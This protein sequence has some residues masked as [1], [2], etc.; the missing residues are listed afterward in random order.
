MLSTHTIVVGASAAGLACAACLKRAGIDH[1]LLEKQPHVA[2]AWRN[3]Y[4]RLHL[5]THKANSGLPFV[6]FDRSVPKY[7]SR[8][9]VVAYLEA[10][11]RKMGLEPVFNTHVTAIRRENNQWLVQ[12]TG[13]TYQAQQVVIAT[14]STHTPKLAVIPGLDSFPGP[15]LH[16]SQYKNGSS[17]SGQ[18]V[19]VVGFGNSGGEQAIDLHEYGAYP[20]MSVRS[21]VNVIPRDVFGVSILQ[22]GLLMRAL[23]PKVV[24]KMNAPLLNALIGDITKLGLRKSADGPLEQIRKTGRI[25]L[26]DIGT[27]RLMREGHIKVYGDIERIAGNQISFKDGRQAEFDAIILA[28]GYEHKLET[29]LTLDAAQLEDLNKPMARRTTNGQNGLYFC[30]FYIS[31]NGMLREMGIEAKLIAQLSQK[32]A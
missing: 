25:P 23:P 5:H 8:A 2:H 18:Q 7:P 22:L 15:V 20:S 9:D 11:V 12:T 32:T 13:E 27:I 28:T 14:G 10:Y 31:P 3:H 16:S 19:L 17:F 30:G 21:A 4:E 1:I 26:L 29:L 6:A 24:D